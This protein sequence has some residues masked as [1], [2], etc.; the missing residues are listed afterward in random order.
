MKG[1]VGKQLMDSIH[2]MRD[3]VSIKS[4]G[5]EMLKEKGRGWR[6]KKKVALKEKQMELE[7]RS[8]NLHKCRN[9]WE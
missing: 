9:N 4:L 7:T 1:V 8:L 5:L 3:L 6:S 2:S